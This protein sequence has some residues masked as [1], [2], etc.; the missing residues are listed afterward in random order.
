MNF[1]LKVVVQDCQNWMFS[2]SC[3]R[4][5]LE[6]N[7]KQLAAFE[8]LKKR[9][10]EEEFK[11]TELQTSLEHQQDEI[12]NLKTQVCSY[13]YSQSCIK[14]TATTLFYRFISVFCYCGITSLFTEGLISVTNLTKWADLSALTFQIVDLTKEVQTKQ[15]LIDRN[16]KEGAKEEQSLLEQL[17]VKCSQ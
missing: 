1:I 7:N 15:D 13:L 4:E 14:S 16:K 2:R 17:Y 9:Y 5:E 10:E 3:L 8:E 12:A 6:E 11:T